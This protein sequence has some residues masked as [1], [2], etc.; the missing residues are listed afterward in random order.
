MIT[1]RGTCRG[2]TRHTSARINVDMWRTE[3]VIH[4]TI[5]ISQ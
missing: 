4:H 5:V 1:R 2:W 3:K